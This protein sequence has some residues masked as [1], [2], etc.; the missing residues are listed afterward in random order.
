MNS[1]KLRT[2]ERGAGTSVGPYDLILL[3]ATI[4]LD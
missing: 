2:T 1:A 4:R 3:K